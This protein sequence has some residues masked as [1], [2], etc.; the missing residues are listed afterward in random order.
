MEDRLLQR[1]RPKLEAEQRGL[2][3]P[4]APALLMVRAGRRRTSGQ[5]LVE[6]AIATPVLIGL[7]LGAFNVAVLVSNKVIAGNAVRQGARLASEIG[8]AQTNPL[9]GTTHFVAQAT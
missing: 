1:G 9:P 3:P 6:L 7:L 4:G 5:S 2:Y 8:G